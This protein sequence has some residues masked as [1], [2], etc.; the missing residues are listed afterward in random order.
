MI[1]FHFAI[2]FS[3]GN[4][5]QGCGCGDNASKAVQEKFKKDRRE[6]AERIAEA[7]AESNSRM[8]G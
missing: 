8:K 3:I 7:L 2:E 4:A 1:R 6:A 5:K